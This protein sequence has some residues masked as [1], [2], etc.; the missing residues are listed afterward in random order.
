MWSGTGPSCRGSPMNKAL[1]NFLAII[2]FIGTI[3]YVLPMANVDVG[4]GISYLN[5]KSLSLL[6]SSLPFEPIPTP[7]PIPT[8]LNITMRPTITPTPAPT[9]SPTPTP[10]LSPTPT[11]TP[12]LSPTPTPTAAPNVTL[13]PCPTP[14]PVQ[15]PTASLAPTATTPAALPTTTATITP[16]PIGNV[17]ITPG[18][19]NVTLG[20]VNGNVTATPAATVGNV[21]ER[22]GNPGSLA[23]VALV[24]LALLIVGAVAW[25][26]WKGKK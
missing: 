23:M 12:T 14:S 3:I 1:L 7:R 4:A 11:P 22:V 16:S 24:I 17:T 21:T 8:L 9:A 19:V 10:T 13:I 6:P 2:L 25:N 15:T 5:L 26:M 18:P 20:P